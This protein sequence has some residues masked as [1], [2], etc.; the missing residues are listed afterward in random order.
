MTGTEP[1]IEQ[2]LVQE[3]ARELRQ[4]KPNGAARGPAP[5]KPVDALA[6]YKMEF[7]APVFIIESLLPNGLTLA[8]GR[9]KVGKSWLMLQLA[10]AV[11]FGERALG[12]F[13]VPHPGRVTYLALEEPAERTHRRLREVVPGPDA[14]LQNVSFIYQIPP[15]MTGGAAQLDAFLTANPSE[16][17]IADTMLALVSAHS[18]RKDVVRGDYAEV[19]M[20]RQIAEKHR[21]AFVCVHHSRKAAGDA[22]DSMIGTS[23]TTAACDS[24]WQLKR[25]G[26]GE[27]GLAVKGREIEEIEYALKFNTGQPFGWQVIG[28]GAEV[29]MS[30]ERR[31]IITVLEQEGALKP[32]QIARALV[33]NSVAIRRLIQKLAFDGLIRRQP[34]GT[35][36]PS[37]ND[38]NGGNA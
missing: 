27:G 26:T 7:P 35:Y 19:N 33:K 37:G 28:E 15:L 36:V 4:A 5:L 32:A 38:G 25:L 13:R 9:P 12:R 23:G 18:G 11:A 1:D 31:D 30:S 6:V 24:V 14:R 22:V 8:A 10:V 29:G 2:L 16:L 20:L 3:H 17:V 21:T 34:N